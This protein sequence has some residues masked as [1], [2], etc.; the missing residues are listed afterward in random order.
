V[1][2]QLSAWKYIKN[3]KRPAAAFVTALSLAF[4]AMYTVYVLL[5]TTPE[6][7]RTLMLE[8]PK[9]IS[10]AKLTYKAYGLLGDQYES[11]EALIEAF[12]QKQDELIQKLIEMWDGEISR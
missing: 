5:I 7:F 2:K 6:S 12:D 1:K 10:Y 8:M 3:N 11:K 9:R 4:M